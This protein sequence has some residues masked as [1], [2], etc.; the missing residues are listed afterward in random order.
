MLI[1]RWSFLD[2]GG[3]AIEPIE[4]NADGLDEEEDDDLIP[5]WVPIDQ[6]LEKVVTTFDYVGQ[7]DDELSFNANMYIY[8][9]KKNDDHWYEGVMKN[10]MGRIISGII[11]GSSIL[12]NLLQLAMTSFPLK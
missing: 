7:R 11:R 1:S 12:S 5:D 10:E 6:C 4:A 3:G 2:D 8:V 9:L